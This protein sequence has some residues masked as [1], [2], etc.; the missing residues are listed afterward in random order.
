[1]R[2][3]EVNIERTHDGWLIVDIKGEKV[4]VVSKSIPEGRS[5]IVVVK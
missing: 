5:M 1:M 4:A 2:Y 3:P